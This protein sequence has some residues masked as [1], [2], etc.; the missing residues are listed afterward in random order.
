MLKNTEPFYNGQTGFPPIVSVIER[1]QCIQYEG[2]LYY[3]WQVGAKTCSL[4]G[5]ARCPLFRGCF[6][7][8][9]YGA[10]LQTWVSVRHN[11][12]VR[13]SEVSVKRCSTLLHCVVYY[14][15][16]RRSGQHISPSQT[17]Q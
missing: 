12:C 15:G 5:I 7:I 13:S 14:I 6:T 11:E 1:F 10:R 4:Y 17:W 16:S 8:G 3:C 2:D 9:V